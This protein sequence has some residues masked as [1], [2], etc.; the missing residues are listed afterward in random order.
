MTTSSSNT[1]NTT[2]TNA[3]TNAS[4]A[5]PATESSSSLP[6]PLP[7]PV[8]SSLALYHLDQG[9]T[10]LI[11][12]QYESA[13]TSFTSAAAATAATA[14]ARKEEEEEEEEMKKDKENQQRIFITFR[15]YSHR[16]ES[17]LRLKDYNNAKVDIERCHSL[18]PLTVSSTLSSTS[19]AFDANE[20]AMSYIRLGMAQFELKE[21]EKSFLALNSAAQI[22]DTA[23]S[24]AAA[25]G[26]ELVGIKYNKN[27]LKEYMEK[28]KSKIPHELQGPSALTSTSTLTSEDVPTTKVIESKPKAASNPAPAPAPATATTTTSTAKNKKPP[29]CPK[30]QYYQSDS[31]MTIAILEPNLTETS[32]KVQISLDKLTVIVQ[33]G[34]KNFTVICGT[35]FSGVIHT[36]CKVKYME[37]KVL[38]KLKKKHNHDWH[39]LFGAG[40][41]NGD[42]D[43]DDDGDGE[44]DEND[45]GFTVIGSVGE[46]TQEHASA[47]TST[48]ATTTRHRPYASHRDWDAVERDLKRE[49]EREKP[50]EG[51][52]FN[53]FLQDMY[54]NADEDT[55]R[56]MIKSYQTSGGTHLS[57]NWSEVE[58]TD[59]EKQRTAPKGQEWR[60]WEGEKLPMKDDD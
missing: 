48:Q 22:Y 28:C 36:K 8:S 56:A 6:L 38:I 47:T 58:K 51:E 15:A 10:F 39:T 41:R 29:T 4:T 2:S 1:T 55:R 50:V 35:L 19:A 14:T 16:A 23:E 26:G 60:N 17:Y 34:G 52:A 57:G 54:K 43:D 46:E 12:N 33:K 7:L 9:N 32:I 24:D 3:S 49:E 30:Y 45:N 53:K 18:L 5:I 25:G 37:E 42:N 21:Y 31:I 59:Y 13:I 27:L 11:N 44:N 20:L 40:E